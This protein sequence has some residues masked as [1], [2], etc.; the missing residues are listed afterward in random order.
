GEYATSPDGV[1]WQVGAASLSSGEGKIKYHNGQFVF[2]SGDNV[3]FS[4]DAVNWS[5]PANAGVSAISDVSHGGGDWIAGGWN[6]VA[7]SPDSVAWTAVFPGVQ[8]RTVGA[9]QGRFVANLVGSG[10]AIYYST[11]P[12]G[13]AWRQA[14]GP[15]GGQSVAFDGS[16]FVM[17]GP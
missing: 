7:V 16:R 4:A 9:G 13:T 5:A 2:W 1:V 11:G 3:R 15:T 14:N 17:T 10:G 8:V 12:G 6:G